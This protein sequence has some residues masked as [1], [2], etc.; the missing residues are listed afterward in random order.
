MLMNKTMSEE[1]ISSKAM[2]NA[3]ESAHIVLVTAVPM[4]LQFFMRPHLSA[5]AAVYRTTAMCNG[6]AEA[7]KALLPAGVHFRSIN[8]ERKISLISD[9]VAVFK[10]I[11]VFRELKPA[12]VHSITPKAGLLTMIA[13]WFTRIPL[14]VHIF[15][16]QVWVTKQGFSRS[17]LKACDLIIARLATHVLADSPSQRR[18]LIEE[19]IVSRDNIQV[20]ADG[21]IAGV[22][23][24][25]FKPDLD[26]RLHVRQDWN[27]PQ[28]ANVILFLGRLTRDKGVLDLINAFIAIA[29]EKDNMYLLIAGPDEENL[30]SEAQHLLQSA[31]GANVIFVGMTNVPHEYMAAADI[32]ALPS[33]REG[34]GSVILEAAA[35]GIPT[36][37]SRIYGITDA[38]VENETGLLHKPGDIDCIAAQMRKLV[39]DKSFREQM[40]EAARQRATTIFSVQRIVEAQMSF[41]RTAIDS[42]HK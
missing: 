8:I 26:A 35:C 15:T 12:L 7:M 33:Y 31:P 27:I 32:F 24:E 38:V 5:I 19:N 21:S 11:K 14:R 6:D 41:Y 29:K 13:G 2:V 40:G 39:F 18:F 37:A 16:G 42:L 3:E 10:L 36:V 1:N 23:S 22:D 28:D 25:R 17:I 9:V 30:Q 4:T 20:L 34:F